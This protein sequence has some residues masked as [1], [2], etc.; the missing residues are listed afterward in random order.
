M[1][2]EDQLLGPPGAFARILQIVQRK[3]IDYTKENCLE[4]L[5]MDKWWVVTYSVLPAIDVMNIMFAL[6]QRRSLLLPQ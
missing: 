4:I 3:L 1:P 2:K 6:L 5:P